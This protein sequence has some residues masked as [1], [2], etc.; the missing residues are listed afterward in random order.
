MRDGQQIHVHI[1]IFLL[2]AQSSDGPDVGDGLY[3]QLGG[4]FEGE[5]L[6]AVNTDNDS[7]LQNDGQDC[8]W[9]EEGADQAQLPVPDD[10]E[11]DGEDDPGNTL[12][13]TPNPGPCGSLYLGAV[14]RQP[15]CGER[16]MMIDVVIPPTFL[17]RTQSSSIVLLQ[18]VPTHF[19]S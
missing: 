11:Y 5:L 8:R 2:T 18:V 10:P 6:N 7:L 13:H 16:E 19:L 12:D 3:S 4:L 14:S 1:D 17:P 9:K 15:G